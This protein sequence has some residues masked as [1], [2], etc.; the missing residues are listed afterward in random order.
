MKR[1]KSN[2]KKDLVRCIQHDLI[3]ARRMN[4]DLSVGIQL[5]EWEALKPLLEKSSYSKYLASWIN[6]M[7]LDRLA[8]EKNK[9]D[10][11]TL[12]MTDPIAETVVEI[13]ED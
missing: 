10:H 12:D 6:I 13:L 4:E 7:H 8:A 11:F 9:F 1:L 5:E 2:W 3:R